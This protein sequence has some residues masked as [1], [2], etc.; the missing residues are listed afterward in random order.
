M[1]I[2]KL[3]RRL[4]LVN[5]CA[6]GL[7]E[8]L[9]ESKLLLEGIHYYKGIEGGDRTFNYKGTEYSYDNS[10]DKLAHYIN[11]FSIIADLESEYADIEMKLDKE[12]K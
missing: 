12:N 5:I 2:D 8:E 7:L 4:K 9:I 6:D 3:K 10:I 11:S 1:E